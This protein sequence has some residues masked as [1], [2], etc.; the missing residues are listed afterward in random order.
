M[1]ANPV[2]NR[3]NGFEIVVFDEPLNLSLPFDLNY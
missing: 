1:G 3:Q 2:T